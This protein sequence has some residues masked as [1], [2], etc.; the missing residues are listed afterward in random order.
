MFLYF[1]RKI[2]WFHSFYLKSNS[3]PY[4]VVIVG[5]PRA[6]VKDLTVSDD[7]PVIVVSKMSAGGRFSSK[8]SPY[9]L[10]TKTMF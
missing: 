1:T 6:A 5:N 7:M 8:S 3:W 9:A 10:H 2:N 4:A